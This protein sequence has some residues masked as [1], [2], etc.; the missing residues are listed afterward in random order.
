[1]PK[2]PVVTPP[3]IEA[4]QLC[5]RFGALRAVDEISFSIAPGQCFGFLG[6]NGA[7]KTTTLSML[8]GL[9]SFDGGSLQVLGQTM[10]Q[11][12]REVRA[13]VGLVPQADNLDPD[14]TV[15]EN[16]FMYARF[17]GLKRRAV[18]DRVE[19]LLAFAELTAKAEA[20]VETL[21]GGMKRRLT[22]ARAL[23]NDPELVI[24]DEPT[25]GLDPQV[26][27]LIWS[28]L[29]ELRSRGVSLILTTH[30]MEEA[31]RLCDRLVIMD[32][33]R[34]LDEGTPTELI[35]RH[36]ESDVIELR[37]RV[38]E[39]LYTTLRSMCAHIERQGL[40]VYVYTHAAAPILEFLGDA[41]QLTVTHRRAGLEDVFLRLTGRGLR[42]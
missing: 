21:S 15:R 22:I 23:V 39:A 1:M 18:A 26:R 2:N 25:T 32:Q 42:E 8:M 11:A 33:G 14:F 35:H 40:A 4:R 7:G 3:V 24:L 29:A 34:I 37:G 30:Y 13:R 10:P 6:P 9:A 20:K 31:E 16:L 19:A 12:A 36:V 27:H 28:R 5:K 38:S 17:F 41:E